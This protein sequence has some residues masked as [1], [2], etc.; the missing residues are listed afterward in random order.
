VVVDPE[1]R[2]SERMNV[3]DG[4]APTLWVGEKGRS[5]G[6]PD[7]SVEIVELERLED[8]MLDLQAL[9]VEL[10]R[11]GHIAVL[12]EGGAKTAAGIMKSG[13]ASELHLFQAPIVFGAGPTWLE[14]QLAETVAESPRLKLVER[15]QVGVDV[16]SH[17]LVGTARSRESLQ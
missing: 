2:L 4:T 13:L 5:R 8:G 6:S 14:G 10:F 3:F 15:E 9:S 1:F 12:V 11:R 16:Y 7:R 17:Y